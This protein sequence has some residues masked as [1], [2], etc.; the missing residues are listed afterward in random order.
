MCKGQPLPGLHPLCIA[1]Q[2]LNNSDLF[3]SEWRGSSWYKLTGIAKESNVDIV[4]NGSQPQGIGT[5]E[6]EYIFC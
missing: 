2:S 3:V 4:G 5:D 1:V 6:A